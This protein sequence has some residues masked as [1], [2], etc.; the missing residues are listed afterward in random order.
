ML[1]PDY[2]GISAVGPYARI[3]DMPGGKY[4]WA[5]LTSL[6]AIASLAYLVTPKALGA[7]RTVTLILHSVL[8]TTLAILILFADPLFPPMMT[9]AVLGLWVCP[10]LARRS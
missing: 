6:T 2:I 10:N 8:W 3:Y 1:L 4:A 7:W 5:V 9:Y